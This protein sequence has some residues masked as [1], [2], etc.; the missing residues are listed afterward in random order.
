MRFVMINLF[1]VFLLFF[2][3]GYLAFGHEGTLTAS[4]PHVDPV[5]ETSSE[6]SQELLKTDR[7]TTRLER[8]GTVK[9]LFSES[10]CRTFTFLIK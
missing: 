8:L 4:E 6:A 2:G 3:I 1:I 9:N 10:V 7:E 5:N